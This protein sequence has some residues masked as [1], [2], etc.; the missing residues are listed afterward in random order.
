M[1]VFRA[2]DELLRGRHAGRQEGA[3]EI[4]TRTLLVAVAVLGVIY[5]AFMGLYAALRGGHNA[6]LQMIA[7][8]AKV[9]LLFVL[10]L[11]VTFP[12]L[13]VFSALARSRL[14]FEPTLRLLLGAMTVN[15]ALLASFGPVTGFFTL[16][17]ESYPFMVV[18]NVAFFAISGLVGLSVLR[19]SL[20][21]VFETDSVVPRAAWQVPPA[22]EASAPRSPGEPPKPRSGN[23][24]R[25]VFRLWTLIYAVVGAQMGWILR[26][27]VGDPHRPF[28]L[29]RERQGNFFLAVL[30]ALASLFR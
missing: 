27:F 11:V 3:I 10:T 19:S 8:M 17:T 24:A 30:E 22:G 7:S 1:G 6:A 21:G 13:Y 16:S 26:P 5:G 20:A 2:I 15:M 28:Q 29:F 23:A 4:G 9:P 14:S 18:L 12:S 25:E